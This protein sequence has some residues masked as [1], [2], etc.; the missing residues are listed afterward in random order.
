V[1]GTQHQ[2]LLG[3][4]VAAAGD[5]NGDGYGDV[6]VAA[7][8][9]DNTESDEG[10]AFV[11]HGS[12]TGLSETPAWTVGGG[13]ADAFLSA[14]GP[15]GDV[16]GDGYSDV[17][18]G[19]P[20][21]TNG[22]SREGIA[23]VYHGSA[24][25]LQPNPAWTQE[26]NADDVRFGWAVW[27]AGDVNGDGYSDVIVGV[28]FAS[29]PTH[30]EGAAVVY[31]GSPTGL[32]DTPSWLVESDQENAGMGISVSTAGD[33]NA[34]GFS[35]VIVGVIRYDNGQS[36]EGG[37][38]VYTGSA[39]GLSTIPSWIG[40]GQQADA[41]FG[42]SVST[43]GDVN[44]D[45]YADVI[46]GARSYDSGQS[47]EGAAFLFHGNA[48]GGLAAAPGQRRADDSAPIAHLGASDSEDSFRLT[49]SGRSPFGRGRVRLEWEVKPLSQSLDG[50]GLEQSDAW[51]D[52]G[53][54]GAVAGA[55]VSG[56]EEE[57]HYHWR[58]RFVYDPVTTPFGQRSR[59][60]TVPLNGWQEGDLRMSV[61]PPAPGAVPDGGDVPGTPLTI[62]R[63][64]AQLQL[65]WGPSCGTLD[66]GYV[67]YEGQMGL[68]GDVS[69]AGGSCE[70]LVDTQTT[71]PLPFA[72]AFYLVVPVNA[73]HEGSYGTDST[74]SQRPFSPSACLPQSI[75]VC[76]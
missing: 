23:R 39:A 12:P 60:F 59:W 52:T 17:I 36:D 75:G 13:Q 15:A 72:N 27:T 34:D 43:A 26:G 64:G 45:G 38:F 44:G 49:L 21:F 10:V 67:V 2:A 42:R 40:E 61:T 56:L 55:L 71:L 14:V 5:V 68:F 65:A 30:R 29:A 37:A 35:D 3:L 32:A 1:R 18:V 69:P 66:T 20:S 53:T 51:L 19:A 70:V 28:P 63:A 62:G 48:G 24:S 46:V 22:L 8:G 58:L 7:P 74:H 4:A 54:A 47:N 33:V 57:S 31:N 41:A 9:Y 11:Y 73:T 16:N 50:S 6:I 25:G 76:E